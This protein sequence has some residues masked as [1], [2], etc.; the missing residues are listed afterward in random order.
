MKVV[1]FVP[2]KM[3]NERLPGKN[4]KPFSDGMTI[5]EMILQKI[6]SVK[7]VAE[8]YVFCSDESIKK[9]IP[10]GV[11]LLIR[12][13][14]LDTA[15][16]TSQD[17]I[18]SFMSKVDADIYLLAHATSPFIK[19]SN[20]EK[21]INKVI[22]EEYDSAFTAH[23]LQ[24]LL[25]DSNNKPINFDAANIPRTQDLSPIYEEVSAAYVFKKETFKKYNRRIGINPYI[26][27]V[28]VI[29]SIDIDQ[30]EDF[31]LANCI[32]TNMLKNKRELL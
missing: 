4:I 1:A 3:N 13:K 25:W 30:Y 14:Y 31:L 7:N 16:A 23:M 28:G 20:I 11:K 27:N 24:K 26:C 17:I 21:C 2:I 8:I 22:N 19:S 6:K 32:Y 29:E 18:K 5:L 12:E 15:E 10:S 9:Y